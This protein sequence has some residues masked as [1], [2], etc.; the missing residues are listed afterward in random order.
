MRKLMRA[1]AALALIVAIVLVWFFGNIVVGM[2]S[3]ARVD[4]TVA[5]LTVRA[6]VTIARDGRG[7]PHVTAQN[8]HDLFY[9]QGYAEGSDRL[10]QMDLLR[11]YVRGELA[12][13]FGSA[14]LPADEAARGV[15]IR[16]IVDG[17][18]SALSANEREILGA[19][20][21]GVNA[22]MERE[23]LPVEFRMLAYKPA[24]W[25]PDDS[26]VVSMATVLDLIDDWNEVARRDR[27][28]R[29]GGLAELAAR[30]PF[31]DPCYD[32]PVTGGL[33]AMGP[34]PACTKR[35]ALL[36]EL[37]DARRP[38]GS[39]EWASGAGR[40]TT[41]RSLLANDP[42]LGLRMPGVWYLIDLSAPGFHAAGASLPGS[43]GVVLG[44]NDR[45]AW[46]A[47]NGTV[48]SLSVFNAPANLDPSGWQSETFHV[49][50]RGD[51]TK[52]YYRGRSE[53]GLTTDDGRFVLVRWDA[54]Q[55]PISPLPTFLRLNRAASLEDAVTALAGYPGPTQNFALSE[56]SGRTAYQLAGV[57]PNDPAWGRWIHPSGDLARHYGSVPFAALPKVAPSRDAVVW[58]ANNKMY[59][60]GYPFPLSAQFAPPYRAYRTA[61]LLRARAKYDVAYFM[62]MQMDVLSLPERDMAHALAPSLQHLDATASA[63][64]RSWDG[65]MRGD[66][67]AA[68]LAY[69]LRRALTEAH[70]GRMPSVLAALRRAPW[71]AGVLEGATIR[72]ALASPPPWNAEGAI[73]VLHAFNSLGIKALNGSVFPG[74]GDAFTLHMQSGSGGVYDSQS[75]RAVWDVG[76]WD[77]GGITIP[78]GESGEPGSGHYLD[79]ADAWLTGTL[80]PLP[81]SAAAVKSATVQ[82]ETLK[83]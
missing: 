39:N 31:T 10:F 62:Q 81:Y 60:P 59:S 58:T 42:H 9:A 63:L 19:F 22:A 50:L 26:L 76:N 1:V 3:S 2:R 83:P 17:Q 78:Q 74:N 25:T 45:I 4:G 49:R 52:R 33:A 21:D 70:N 13:V 41:G 23:P 5:G 43:P 82:T 61:Q 72:S 57:I 48:A 24:P 73:P 8:L 20:S 71:P 30:F 6:P 29:E 77:V 69:R 75:F 53:F 54:Y 46:A 11:R 66:S 44:H 40:T 65:E 64:L 32:A 35:V 18:W 7:V 80:L 38:I 28:Y 34:G 68:T 67:V 56:S 12:E 15:P 14:A 47:T 27:A 51:T 79:Q 16:A 37:G 55:R 36:R